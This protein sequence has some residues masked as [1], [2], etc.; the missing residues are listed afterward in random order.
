MNHGTLMVLVICFLSVVIKQLN[1]IYFFF[2]QLLGHESS[3]TSRGAVSGLGLCLNELL[4][5]WHASVVLAVLPHLVNT[6]LNPYWLVKV[7]K[8]CKESFNDGQVYY[9]ST[10]G[11]NAFVIRNFCCV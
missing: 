6:A 3:V 11:K 7:R 9:V 5:S 4:H 1:N 10:K 8:S 2:H